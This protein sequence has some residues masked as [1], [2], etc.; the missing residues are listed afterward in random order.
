MSIK[1]CTLNVK[2]LAGKNK[3]IQVFEWLKQNKV[4]SSFLQELHCTTENY[5]LWQNEWKDYLFLS[6]NTSNSLGIGNLCNNLPCK[7][8]EHH[9]I[10]TGRL[11][12]LRF[13][14]QETSYYL[15]N[16]YGYT[17]D[18]TSLFNTLNTIIMENNDNTFIIG[19]EF[20]TIVNPLL[21]KKNGNLNA[22]KQD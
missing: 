2:G 1:L 5:N 8:F 9:D 13:T 7:S 3:R 16:V 18:D 10:I 17:Q 11:Q 14:I 6:G 12:T 4:N 15:I 20:N 21:D 22:H 19:G